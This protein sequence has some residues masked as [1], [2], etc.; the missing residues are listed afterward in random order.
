VPSVC[1]AA[2]PVLYPNL[3]ELESYM[4]LTLSSEEL[5]KNLLP[6]GSS[7]GVRAGS[8]RLPC[9]GSPCHSVAAEGSLRGRILP[10]E[11]TQ[12]PPEG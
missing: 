7:V 10:G 1:P 5:Q 12:H 3:A 8:P 6:E 2:P 11:G 9:A 4:G